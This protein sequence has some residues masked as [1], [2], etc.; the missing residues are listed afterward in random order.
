MLFLWF[1]VLFKD[2]AKLCLFL[3]NQ[4]DLVD[5]EIILKKLDELRFDKVSQLL[6]EFLKIR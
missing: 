1:R 4:L 2:L 6:L 5:A 3:E